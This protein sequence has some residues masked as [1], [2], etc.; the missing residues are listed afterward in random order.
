MQSATPSISFTITVTDTSDDEEETP[1]S[2][3][4]SEL[5][6]MVRR[7]NF[8]E[9]EW[10]CRDLLIAAFPE[11]VRRWSI[12][13][14]S[15]MDTMDLLVETGEYDPETAIQ[16]MKLL[17]DTAESHLQDPEPAY[18]LLG[19]E[20][21]DL[22]LSGYIRPRLLDHLKT[23]DRL[24]RQLFQSAYVGSPQEDILLSCSQLSERELR[25]KLLDLLAC[26]PFPH[27]EI[28]LGPYDA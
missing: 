6:D 26:N 12:D 9:D 2:F 8:S 21:Y 7:W 19:N 1:R 10:A 20:L 22:C 13:E 17:L 15:E 28:E 4:R 11:A 16:M 23:D 18:F 3:S 5:E 14:L 27:D 25:Q 24:A